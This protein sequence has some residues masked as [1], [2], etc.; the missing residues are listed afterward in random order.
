MKTR[1]HLFFFLG[2][3]YCA[4]CVL[5]LRSRRTIQD[6]PMRRQLTLSSSVG[7]QQFRAQFIQNKYVRSLPRQKRVD[8]TSGSF[9]KI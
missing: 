8:N 7:K 5:R 2:S 6:N 9:E 4:A 1:N 3:R